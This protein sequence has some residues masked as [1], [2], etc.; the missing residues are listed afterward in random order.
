MANLSNINGKFVVEQT[1]GYVGVGTTDPNYPIEVLNASAEIAL[2]ASGGSIYRVQSDSASN[3]I[4]RKEG[5]GDRLVINSA[6]NATFAGSVTVGGADDATAL[7]LKR[8]GGANVMAI[9]TNANGSWTMFD[10]AAGTYTSGITQKSGNVGI[11]ETN[12]TYKFEVRGSGTNTLQRWTTTEGG[13]LL[14]IPDN[15]AANP[16]WTFIAGTNED[17]QIDPANNDSGLIVKYSGNV[18]IGTAVPGGSMGG[19]GLYT[20]LDV[21]SSGNQGWLRVASGA[22]GVDV[23]SIWLHPFD[24]GNAGW[25]MGT[26]NDGKLRLGYGSGASEEAAVTSAK[27][28]SSGITIQTNGNV[29]IGTTSPSTLLNVNSLSGTTYPT[30]GTASGVI[31]ISINELHGMYLGVDGSSGNGWIQAMREDATATAYNLILQPSGGNVGIG[32]TSPW[33]L[34]TGYTGL[35]IDDTTTGFLAIRSSGTSQVVLSANGNSYLNG[36]NVG[37]GVTSPT[38]GKLVVVGSPYVITDSGRAFGGIDLR[39]PT[40]AGNGL[41][42]AG[43]SFG[44]SST[45]SAA[46]SGIQQNADGDVQGLAFFTHGSSG[47][48]ADS[49]ERMRITSTGAISVG[50]TGTAYGAAGEVLT[51]NGNASPSWQAAGGG[52]SAWPQEKFAVYTINSTTSNI[53]IATMNSTT[54]HGDQFGGCLKFTINDT[55]YIQVSYVTI[56]TFLSQTNK[57]FFKGN[58]EMTTHNTG[59]NPVRYVF[60]FAGNNGS[61]GTTCTLK[62]NRASSG[63]SNPVNVLVQAISSPD[64]FILN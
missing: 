60:A 20:K 9:N 38:T 58:V 59:T 18:G 31:A 37:I 54:W 14:L 3:F 11:G 22:T 29:G 50:S 21:V 13:A 1:T 28:G 57:W 62:I 46:I 24:F 49:A 25:Q 17:I 7:F 51:S 52:G 42:S 4:I 35:T 56:Y 12:P 43:I 40:N 15:D 10:Y 45:A 63:P 44:G 48:T 41:Y 27:D 61:Y 32:T 16:D 5:V 55:N 30:L 23:A 26:N 2:N 8:S 47:S 6:G 64:M 33:D 36:G 34:G 19:Y 39:T 53:L